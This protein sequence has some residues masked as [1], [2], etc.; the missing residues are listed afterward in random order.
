[1]SYPMTT[2][3]AINDERMSDDAYIN[4]MM[5]VQISI[6]AEKALLDAVKKF[7]RLSTVGKIDMDAVKAFIH[8]EWPD[9]HFMRDE[10]EEE[11]RG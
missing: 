7:N 5:A 10:I 8:D 11:Y 1:M 2:F 3:E 9:A 4:N 6:D